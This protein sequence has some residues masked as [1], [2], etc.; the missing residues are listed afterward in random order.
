MEGIFSEL[1]KQAPTAAAIILVA[2][3]FL[4]AEKQREERRVEADKKSEE[5]RVANAK[6][7]EQERQAHERD[8]NNMWANFVKRLIDEQ[9]KSFRDVVS[10]I[11][12]HEDSAQKRYERLKITR[13][14]KKAAHAK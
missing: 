9:A 12:R 10:E 5:T 2:Y 13:D 8:I 4:Q 6:A 3:M 11:H 1:I 14:L 7:L